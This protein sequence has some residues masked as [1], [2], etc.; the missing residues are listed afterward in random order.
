M[1]RPKSKD[2]LTVPTSDRPVRR[3]TTPEDQERENIGLAVDLAGRHLRDG[4]A[5][6]MV[7]VHYLKMATEEHKLNLRKMEGEIE[8]QKARIDAIAQGARMEELF[9]EAI[10]AITTYQGGD[11]DKVAFE[12]PPADTEGLGELG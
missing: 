10:K 9:T 7:Q 3:A 11:P 12:I 1:A 8:L 2:N 6:S 4:T 5:S